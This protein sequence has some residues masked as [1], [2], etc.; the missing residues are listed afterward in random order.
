LTQVIFGR[1]NIISGFM[2]PALLGLGVD[3]CI[4]VHVTYRAAMAGVARDDDAGRKAAI[5]SVIEE[6]LVPSAAAAFTTSLGFAALMLNEFKGVSE[7]GAIAALGLLMMFGVA[8]LVFPALLYWFDKSPRPIQSLFGPPPSAADKRADIQVESSRSD[9]NRVNTIAIAVLVV[10]G[11]IMVVF[12]SGVNKVPYY[13]DYRQ[14]RGAFDEQTFH[15]YIMDQTGGAMGAALVLANDE[16]QARAVVDAATRVKDAQTSDAVTNVKRIFSMTQLVPTDI[17]VHAAEIAKM[18]NALADLPIRK[19]KDEDKKAVESLRR[20]TQVSPPKAEEMPQYFKERLRSP[21]GKWM[22]LLFAGNELST[23]DQFVTWTEH[24]DTVRN[25]VSK[26]GPPPPIIDLA[27]VGARLRQILQRTLNPMIALA[28][29]L[30]ALVTVWAFRRTA[31][32]IGVLVALA[33]GVLATFGAIPFFGMHLNLYNV[34]IVPSIVGIGIDNA[35]HIMHGFLET[36]DIR[37]TMSTRG[38]ACFLCTATT[39]VGYGA[40]LIANHGGIRSLG[41]LAVLGM[42]CIFTT[43]TLALPAVLALIEKRIFKKTER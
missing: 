5:A 9:R 36:R 42:C 4:H 27:S 32:T 25:I 30:V 14:M 41:H 3:F 6:L 24:I 13:N 8:F 10:V 29:V 28:C 40:L 2:L 18:D 21:S 12:I 26:Q 22:V 35:I 7:Y 38:L 20:F 31:P 43:T 15:E 17:D 11:A 1:L 23:D 19:M 37:K 39:G 33:I 16:A 34:V